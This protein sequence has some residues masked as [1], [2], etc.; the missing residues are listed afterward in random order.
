LTRQAGAWFRGRQ[1]F[2]SGRAPL[3]YA[4]CMQFRIGQ[5][6][7]KCPHC[8]GLEFTIPPDER[9]G[10]HMSY[11]CAGC[12]RPVQYAKLVAQIGREAQRQRQQRLGSTG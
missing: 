3:H 11:L 8:E 9:S 5:I 6:S 1:Y 2:L 7:A 4:D 12:G 10:P